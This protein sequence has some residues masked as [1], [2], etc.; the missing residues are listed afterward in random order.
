MI[1]VVQSQEMREI[2]R[3]SIESYGIP[4]T[5]LMENAGLEIAK[6]ALS[7]LNDRKKVIIFCGKGNNGGDGFVAARHLQNTDKEVL[8]YA[9]ADKK[10]YHGDAKLNLDILE[11]CKINV[12]PITSEETLTS[13]CF[14]A[15]LIIDALL[16]TGISGPPRDLIAKIIERI[17]QSKIPTLSVDTPSGLHSKM[18]QPSL[19]VHADTTITIG[20]PKLPL[21]FHPGKSFVGNLK[22]ASI[23]F[24]HTL[25]SNKNWQYLQKSDMVSQLPMRKDDSYK[26][27]N[28]RLLIIAG[29]K[30]LSGAAYLTAQAA[31]RSGCGMVSLAIPESL[32][33]I[34]EIKLTEAMT[35]SLPEDQHQKIDTQRSNKLLQDS[36]KKFDTVILGPGIGRDPQTQAFVLEVIRSCPLPLLIDA[37]GLYPLHKHLQTLQERTQTTIITPHQGE[38]QHMFEESLSIYPDE[39]LEQTQRQ[40]QQLQTIIHLK[41]APAITATASHVYINSSGNASLATA[42]SGDVLSGIAG[43]FLAQG[44]TPARAMFSAAYLHGYIADLYQQSQNSKGL[45]ASDLILQLPNALSHF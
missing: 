42:G 39:R 36:Y 20:C 33:S 17:N 22:I 25:L 1:S 10:G 34:M 15:D 2:D 3:I 35:L 38:Y 37:D 40:S 44:L 12:E 6:E 8:V 30:G 13:L 28:G 19:A 7:L 4:S 43:A 11:K 29:S 27:Q 31:C 5:S 24:P 26:Q 21:L 18:E 45:I 9:S 23:G 16:G 41:G 14:D 32:N